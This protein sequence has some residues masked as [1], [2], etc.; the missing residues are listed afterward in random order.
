M[1]CLVGRWIDGL[2]VG[3]GEK[4]ASEKKEREREREGEVYTTVGPA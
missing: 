2:K 3:K 4:R 1:A